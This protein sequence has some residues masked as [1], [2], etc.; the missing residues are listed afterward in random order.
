MRFLVYIGLLFTTILQSCQE[1]HQTNEAASM[2]NI[3][4]IMT[5]DHAVDAI[6]AYNDK[7]IRTPNIDRIAKQGLQFNEAF[8]TNSICGPSRA[9][10]LTGKMSHKNGFMA[11]TD[12]FDGNQASL[13][14]YLQKAGYYTSIQGKWHLK[15][16][17]QGFDEYN[18]L[19]DQGEYYQPRFYNGTDTSVTE[20]YTTNVITDKALAVLQKKKKS[21]KP[22]FLMVHHKAPH[23]NWMPDTTHLINGK[24]KE[25]PLPETFWDDYDSRSKAAKE[26]DMRIENMFLGMDM[27]MKL[28]NGQASETGT[29]GNPTAPSYKWWMRDYDRLTEAQ[30]QV[31]DAYYDPIIQSFKESKLSDKEL[32]QWKYQRYMNDYLKCVQSVDDNV[33][34]ILDYLEENN[35]ADNTLVIYTSDQGFYL[36][37]HGWYDKRFMYEPSFR[38]PLLIQYPRR[39]KR[40]KSIHQ[41][42]QNVD[43]APTILDAA[44]IPVPKEMQGKSLTPFFE[45]KPAQWRENLY[46][47]YYQDGVWHFVDKHLGIRTSRYKLIYF[48]EIDTWELYDLQTDPNE[49]NNIYGQKSMQ[50]LTDSLKSEL[51]ELIKHYDDTTAPNIQ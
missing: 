51:K 44:G 11:N 20:G 1:N 23:R 39:I 2:P 33:G 36:G 27:K 6:S 25:Y 7:L 21:D 34:R 8:V 3:I 19:I 49:L 9:V 14:K 31:W 5:D 37:E 46:Y 32:T 42:V 28:E 22:I 35:M 43:F 50:S 45:E 48:Y 17:P 13:P 38:T 30:Q 41:L 47:H 4:F 12:V 24:E 10:I 16:E 18:I 29:G 15:T 26:Q 40:S